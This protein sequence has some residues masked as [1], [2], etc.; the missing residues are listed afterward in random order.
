MCLEHYKILKEKFVIIT[1]MDLRMAQCN[2]YCVRGLK[3]RDTTNVLGVSGTRFR[4][5]I[6]PQFKKKLR[7]RTQYSAMHNNYLFSIWVLLF[8]FSS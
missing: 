2:N 6:V 5:N 7:S 8:Q 1:D 4:D 3:L